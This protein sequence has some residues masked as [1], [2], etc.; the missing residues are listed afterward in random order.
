VEDERREISGASQI[1]LFLWIRE[2]GRTRLV[3]IGRTLVRGFLRIIVPILV[4]GLIKTRVRQEN[5]QR[6]SLGQA[7]QIV[8]QRICLV[9]VFHD[10]PP[11]G[12]TF[13]PPMMQD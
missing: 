11:D 3:E 5:I 9:F 1:I 2:A 8:N 4:K 10:T 12:C 6:K 13:D 7:I